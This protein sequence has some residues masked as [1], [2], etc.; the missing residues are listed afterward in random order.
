MLTALLIAL[1]VIALFA[2]VAGCC[3][4][5]GRGDLLSFITAMELSK[6]VPII[7]EGIFNLIGEL[8]SSSK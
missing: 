2:T 7:L 8:L 6:L 4:L 5:W 3:W 1:L